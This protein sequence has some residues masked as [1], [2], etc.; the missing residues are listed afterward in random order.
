MRRLFDDL[1]HDRRRQ[2]FAV[3]AERHD[4][5]PTRRAC[6]AARM[7]GHRPATH[8]GGR[9]CLQR[10]GEEVR[11]LRPCG[12]DRSARRARRATDPSRTASPSSSIEACTFG[13][14]GSPN[15]PYSSSAGTPRPTP[16]TARPTTEVVERR[17]L[18]GE[19]VRPPTGHRCHQGAQTHPS[20]CESRRR[21]AAPT[22]RGRRGACRAVG[23][24]DPRGRSRPTRRSRRSTARS[25]SL[26]RIADVRR[27]DAPT[28]ARLYT[29]AV[30]PRRSRPV[31]PAESVS[32]PIA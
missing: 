17:H 28:H 32:A 27:A 29:I 22:D 12:A 6:A 3:A 18:L 9:G 14:I 25:T 15:A 30:T 11:G 8:T 31:R 1:S 19:H 16:S 13:S 2:G 26:R 5:V 23:G 4:T 7:F 24:G 10:A 20:S 21:R